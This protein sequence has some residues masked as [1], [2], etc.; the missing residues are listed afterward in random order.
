MPITLLVP[1]FNMGKEYPS[2]NIKLERVYQNNLRKKILL[3]Y[4]KI[5]QFYF[6][7]IMGSG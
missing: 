2:S 3:L 4:F 1:S 5:I 6:P 7:W